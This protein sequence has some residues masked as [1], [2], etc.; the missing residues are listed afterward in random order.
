MFISVLVYVTF[1]CYIALLHCYGVYVYKLLF[2]V[3]LQSTIIMKHCNAMLQCY[4]VTVDCDSAYVRLLGCNFNLTCWVKLLFEI[5][6]III[7]MLVCFETL[8][9]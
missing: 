5:V 7:S 9:F 1:L 2:A 3:W 8:V 4:V 6:A